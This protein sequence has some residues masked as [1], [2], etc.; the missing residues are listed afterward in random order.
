M[1][2]KSL[3][4]SYCQWK[5]RKNAGQIHPTTNTCQQRS[6]KASP[7]LFDGFEKVEPCQRVYAISGL[8]HNVFHQPLSYEKQHGRYLHEQEITGKR[9]FLQSSGSPLKIFL[10]SF[11]HSPPSVSSLPNEEWLR[12]MG[13]AQED[14]FFHA[15]VSFPTS[16]FRGEESPVHGPMLAY[17]G[18]Q[19]GLWGHFPQTMSTCQ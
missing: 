3:L 5:W 13:K 19:L 11:S 2:G 17:Q 1:M 6:F 12:R 15:H 18:V 7:L 14:P 8:L 9:S 4:L 16:K 10:S